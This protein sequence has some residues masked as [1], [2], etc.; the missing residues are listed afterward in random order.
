MA[1]MACIGVDEEDFREILAVKVG[2]LVDEVLGG[3][4][5]KASHGPSRPFRERSLLGVVRLAVELLI[6]DD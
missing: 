3:E 6:L 1:L 5:L 4:I 2:G